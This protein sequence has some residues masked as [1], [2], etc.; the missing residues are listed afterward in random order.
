MANQ[1]MLQY[2]LDFGSGSQSTSNNHGELNFLIQHQPTNQNKLAAFPEHAA[3]NGFT[4][5]IYHDDFIGFQPPN[6]QITIPLSQ[7]LNFP[8]DSIPNV[9]EDD[10]AR[11]L[12]TL[13][14]IMIALVIV[15]VVA[16]GYV[17][18]ETTN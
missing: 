14:G 12:L 4:T 18:H 15:G 8:E 2:S 16:A 5:N 6:G 9:R 10:A 11:L 17:I 7:I 13:G 3:S 1:V